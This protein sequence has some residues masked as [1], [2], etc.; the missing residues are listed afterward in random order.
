MDH[1]DNN[2][3]TQFFST[4]ALE[5]LVSKFPDHIRQIV[6]LFIFGEL[7][8]AYQN[9]KINHITHV[10]MVLCAYYFLDLWVHFLDRAEYSKSKYF[11]LQKAANIVCIVI[12]GLLGLIVIYCDH[13]GDNVYPL[14]F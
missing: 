6:Y 2:A 4:L 8:D 14:L 1:Q 9:H 13:L 7:V 11:I 12:E 3:V 10:K 5:Y